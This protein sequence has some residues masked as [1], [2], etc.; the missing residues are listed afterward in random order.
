MKTVSI[1]TGVFIAVSFS[2]ALGQKK[3]INNQDSTD[4]IKKEHK[5]SEQI[6]LKVHSNDNP[7]IKT[8]SLP[9]DFPQFQ[10][11]GNSEDNFFTF[12]KKKANWFISNP[13][14][15]EK[16]VGLTR[17]SEDYYKS[18]SSEVKRFIEENKNQFEILN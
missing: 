15:L 9:A 2:T 14:Y 7:P 12:I 10:I 3:I 1:I 4:K 6:S 5:G 18:L 11:D 13:Q 17:I 16:G 8:E